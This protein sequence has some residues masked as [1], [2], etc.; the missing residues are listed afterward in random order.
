[1]EGFIRKRVQFSSGLS[2]NCDASF[3][4]SWTVSGSCIDIS[5]D[6]GKLF[7]VFADDS[8]NHLPHMDADFDF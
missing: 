7:F 2:W 8:D 5:A 6:E 4:A 1:M 3:V